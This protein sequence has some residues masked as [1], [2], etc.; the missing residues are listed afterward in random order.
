MSKTSRNIPEISHVLTEKD[1][2]TFKILNVNVS[3]VNALRRTILSDIPTAVFETTPYE[4]NKCTI[5]ENTSR[6]NNEIL[7]QRLSCVPIYIKDLDVL[8]NLQVELK[9]ENISDSVM[10]ITTNDFKI[11]DTSTDK[12]LS[13]TE[14]KKIFPSDKKTGE[15]ILFARLRSKIAK[16][17]PGEKISLTC[18]ITSSTAN[19]NGAFNVVS[20]CAYSFDDDIKRQNIEWEKHSKT[21]DEEEK[22]DIQLKKKNWFNHAAKRFYKDDVFNFIIETIGVYSNI[23]LIKK[24]CNIIINKLNTLKELYNSNKGLIEETKSSIIKNC[25]DV[26]LP[27]EDYTIGKIIEYIIHMDFYKNGS[28]LSYIGFIKKHPHDTDSYIRFAFNQEENYNIDSA[29][30]IL[31]HGISQSTTIINHINES[32]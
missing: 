7:K 8:D 12:Y 22:V 30:T 15:Y 20:T 31:N 19:Q 3:F 11:K 28:E 13:D 32:F 18:K 1:I 2:M 21:L 26:T 6:L 16:T 14:V 27:N 23:E 29:L 10:Y 9:K 24:A 4:N 25:Y 17:L 5:S